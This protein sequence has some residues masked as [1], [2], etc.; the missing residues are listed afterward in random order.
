MNFG[1]IISKLM[2]NLEIPM[3]VFW[4][5]NM[6]CCVLSQTLKAANGKNL[7]LLTQTLEL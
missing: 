3:A 2:Y 1:N 7:V 6:V 5:L 4:K